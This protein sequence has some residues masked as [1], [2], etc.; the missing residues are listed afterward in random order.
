MVNLNSIELKSIVDE[1]KE[2]QPQIYKVDW[3]NYT[4]SALIQFLKKFRFQIFCAMIHTFD[5]F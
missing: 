3:I 1:V 5:M 4:I 2:Y